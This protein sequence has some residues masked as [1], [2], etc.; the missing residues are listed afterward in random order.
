MN[1]DEIQKKA[2]AEWEALEQGDKPHIIVGTATCGRA[3]GA[4]AVIE[5][6]KSE[7]AKRKIEA[8]ITQVGCIGMCYS[9]PLVD[10]AKPNKPRISYGNV[11]PETV[12]QLIEGYIINDDP[13]PDLALGTT[14]D[15]SIDGIPKFWE[16]PMLKPQVRI[17]L[18]NCGII[19]PDKIN[20]YIARG[21]YSG[22]AK[23]LKV[24]PQE[25]IDEIKK[26]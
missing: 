2:K 8:D 1:F 23:A 6:I 11:T 22:I 20:H 26:S 13:L 4:L 3:A 5:A 19:D 7:L 14:G 24:T 21:G 17:A 25:I 9:E 18:R 10:I 15:G 16:L 12:P